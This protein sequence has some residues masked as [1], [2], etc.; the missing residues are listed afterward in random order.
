MKDPAITVRIATFKPLRVLIKGE[1]R[2][3]DYTNFRV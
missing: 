1:V 2:N 3:P